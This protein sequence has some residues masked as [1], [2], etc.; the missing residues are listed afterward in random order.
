[1]RIVE[2][3]WVDAFIS[4]DDFTLKKAKKLKPIKRVTVGHLI[5]VNKDCIIMCTD[6]YPKHKKEISTP[7][8]IPNTWVVEVI[9]YE[10][11]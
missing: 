10:D 3:H 7:M 4:T 1:M 9:E 8:V 5:D 2:V 11:P 6:I